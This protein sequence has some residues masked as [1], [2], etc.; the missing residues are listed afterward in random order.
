[1]TDHDEQGQGGGP[2]SPGTPGEPQRRGRMEFQ[3]PGKTTPR[4]PSLA[5]QRARERAAVL[6]RERWLAE[7]ESAERKARTRRRVLIGSGV[8]VGVVALVAVWYAAST[9]D[10]VVA[11]CVDSNGVIVDDDYC[12]ENYARSHGGY[13]SGGHVYIGG[14]QYHYH[15][16]GTGTYG[17][18]V[19][20]G[21][22]LR[23]G[24]AEV[25]TKSGT[26]IQRGGFGISG[27]GGSGS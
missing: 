4:P 26:V 23:P 27:K 1:M 21:T 7:Q 13:Y 9:P 12:D 6:E 22:T 15:Y 17:Q 14:N 25:R 10:R 16:G 5:E 3:E 8:S 24:N 18:K 2:V 19:T 20:G 11:H